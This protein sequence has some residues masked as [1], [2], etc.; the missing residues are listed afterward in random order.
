MPN[1]KK[2]KDKKP[3]DDDFPFP[4]KIDDFTFDGFDIDEFMEQ[5]LPFMK[6]SSFGR[7]IDNMIKELM[8][9]LQRNL[10]ADTSLEDLLRNQFVYGFQIGF[11]PDGKPSF[12][13]FGN[14]KPKGTGHIE[15][16]DVRE[17]LIDIFKEKDKVRVIAEVPGISKGDIKLTG[18]ES[19]LSIKAHS[20]DRKYEKKIDLPVPVK[21]ETAKAK[22]NNGVLEVVIQRKEKEKDEG[23]SIDIQ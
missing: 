13:Q 22:Y 1:D 10:D 15:T 18:S 7:M 5:F 3:D 6:G 21:I 19:R 16:Y 14:V 23:V 9:N 4:F 8:K 17:P 12:R 11:D 2:K 20:K